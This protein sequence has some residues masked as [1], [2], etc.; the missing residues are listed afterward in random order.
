MLDIVPNPWQAARILD[1]ALAALRKRAN[2]AEVIRLRLAL[3]ED[4]KSDLGKQIEKAAED[5]FRRKVKDGD[6]AF[7]LLA[8]PLDDLNANG[9]AA[10]LLVLETKGKY[11]EGNQNTVL[12][13]KFFRLLEEAYAAAR[14]APLDAGKDGFAEKAPR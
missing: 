4:I 7:K 8:A 6:I 1:H 12:K 2:E 13:S 3:I 5:V 9:D 10:R 11:L 14:V